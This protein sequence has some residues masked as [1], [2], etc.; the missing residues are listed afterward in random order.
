VFFLI[1]CAFWLFIVFL[2]LPWPESAPSRPSAK[3]A[4]ATSKSHG[5]K[6][7]DKDLLSALFAAADDK[8]IAAARE[9]CLAQPKDCLS[10]LG[11][12]LGQSLR[13]P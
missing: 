3:V 6:P 9:R 1:K 12:D 7:Q 5:L 8:L 11:L 4:A 10:A 2:V 13:R